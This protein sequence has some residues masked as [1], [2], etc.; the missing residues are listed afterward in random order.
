MIVISH[1]DAAL[2]LKCR[3]AFLFSWVW[4]FNPPEKLTGPLALGTRVHA[5]LE[6]W[7][8]DGD[9]PLLK[10]DW[11]VREDVT[12]LED[13][14]APEWE[15]KQ[16]YADA[17][18]G[19]NCV[20]AY[21]EWLTDTGADQGLTPIGVEQKLEAP[22][23]DGAVMLRAKLDL[24]F[25]RDDGAL[26]GADFKTTGFELGRVRAELERS[27]QLPW[28]DLVLRLSKPD[29]WISA[30]EYR[31]MKKVSRRQ[32]GAPQ[33]ECFSLPG[34]IKRRP[35]TRQNIEGICLDIVNFLETVGDNINHKA[36]PSPADYCGWCDY[37][38]PCLVAS[39]DTAAANEMLL[40][41]FGTDRHA[42][43]NP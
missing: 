43:Y 9:D 39:E 16:M 31:I 6:A 20:V 5:A 42:R 37:R 38:A 27:Y 3:R 14:G 4:N 32:R 41:Q 23:L 34:L 12:K 1:S 25:Q 29:S 33:I 17:I 2:F 8:A 18:V 35:I 22:L 15:L 10:H 40:S 24:L 19:R 26:I 11:L 7:Y 30:G 28:Y 13:G 21:M 36:Y